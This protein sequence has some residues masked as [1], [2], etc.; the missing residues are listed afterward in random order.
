MQPSQ[1]PRLPQ[2]KEI[3]ALL[4]TP[5][6][7]TKTLGNQEIQD[8]TKRLKANTAPKVMSLFIEHKKQHEMCFYYPKNGY[9]FINKEVFTDLCSALIQRNPRITEF[10]FFAMYDEHLEALALVLER[11]QIDSLVI[12]IISDVTSKNLLRFFDALQKLTQTQ[13]SLTFEKT[14]DDQ[15]RE[16]KCLLPSNEW[17]AM[18]KFMKANKDKDNMR[19]EVIN[20]PTF[21][22][23]EFF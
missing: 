3:M 16:E 6:P 23:D 15:F 1:A 12:S 21:P 5:Q 20:L 22:I 17:L 14:S 11:C 8:L 4:S 13:I 2:D 10:T 19:F 18:D 7:T 9:D